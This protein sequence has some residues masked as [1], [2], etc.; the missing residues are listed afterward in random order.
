[1]ILGN[2]NIIIIKCF[3]N[4]ISNRHH[5]LMETVHLKVQISPYMLPQWQGT[6]RFTSSILVDCQAEL[7]HLSL[8]A[9]TIA[10]ATSRGILLRVRMCF[11]W[12]T[13]AVV[14]A[15]VVERDTMGGF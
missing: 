5:W 3:R 10:R 7:Y 13:G 4:S 14:V 15:V 12:G 11:E 9:P 6:G 2:S 8:C 1:M